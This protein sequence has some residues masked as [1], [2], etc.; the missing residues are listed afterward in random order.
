[1]YL[2]WEVC[3]RRGGL[4]LRVGALGIELEGKLLERLELLHTIR[5]LA[6][7]TPPPRH[8]TDTHAEHHNHKNNGAPDDG[9]RD[10]RRLHHSLA[11]LRHDVVL[12][13]VLDDAGAGR[14][15][16]FIETSF[17]VCVLSAGCCSV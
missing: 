7:G 17:V 12:P 13:Q 1:M 3:Q 4:E 16:P 2:T 10:V 5:R 15:A 14:R 6:R 8:Q 9:R 11:A